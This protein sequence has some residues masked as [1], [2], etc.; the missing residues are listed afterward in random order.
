[1]GEFMSLIGKSANR[2][3]MSFTEIGK[4][5]QLINTLQ[6]RGIIIFGDDQI[7]SEINKNKFKNFNEFCVEMILVCKISYIDILSIKPIVNIPLIKAVCLMDNE[8]FKQ[9][10]KNDIANYNRL[11]SSLTD[12]EKESLSPK[13]KNIIN[14]DL[15]KILKSKA[16]PKVSPVDDLIPNKDFNYKDFNYKDFI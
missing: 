15:I 4:A 1:M 2:R 5:K 10:K 16:Q 13:A 9:V 14:K 6:D 12:E 8:Y 3:K 7:I 11:I